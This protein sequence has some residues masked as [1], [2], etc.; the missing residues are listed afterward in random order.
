[1]STAV[2]IA[3]PD[4]AAYVGAQFGSCGF[5]LLVRG[6]TPG[7]YTLVA[8]ARSTVSWTFAIA[9]MVNVHVEASAIVVL[10]TPAA[11]AT[12]GGA[13]NVGGWAADLSASSGGGVDVVQAY[14]YPLDTGGSP[15]FL[16]QAS[17]NVA[18]PDVASFAGP[19]FG[20]VG[21]NLSAPALAPGHYRVVA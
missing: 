21:F 11:G 15:I 8:Y 13:F 10:D 18:R 9:Q 20:Q 4:V 14:A 5:S 16:G 3:R 1:G 17:V 19:Q 12:I 7:D 6:L 2:N